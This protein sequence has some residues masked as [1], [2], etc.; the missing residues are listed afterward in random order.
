MELDP[1]LPLWLSPI[2]ASYN[3]HL[4]VLPKAVYELMFVTVGIK[5]YWEYR[6]LAVLAH[7]ACTTAIFA[8][9]FRRIGPMALLVAVPVAFFGA[10]SEF[11]LWGVN[12]GF[13][14]SIALGVSALMLIDRGDRHGYLGACALL[15]VGLLFSEIALLFAAGLAVE[16]TW[17]D[18]GFRRVWVWAVPAALYVAWWLAYYQA[19]LGKHAYGAVPKFIARLAAGAAGGMF[20]L[21]VHLGWG[22]LA[23]VIVG[24]AVVVVRRQVITPRLVGLAVTLAVFWTL[25]AVGRAQ[26]GDPGASRYV[27]MGSLLL[28][29][30]CGRG[31]PRPTANSRR[32]ARRD[33][34]Q[35]TVAVW[36]PA[37]LRARGILAAHGIAHRGCRTGCAPLGPCNSSSESGVGPRLGATGRCRTL[38]RRGRCAGLD[39]RRLSRSDPACPGADACRRRRGADTRRG[40]PTGGSVPH[41]LG[42]GSHTRWPRGRGQLVQSSRVPLLQAQ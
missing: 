25:V 18:R 1:V 14:A 39:T 3:Q 12:F 17:R 22:V 5:H 16:L 21:G 27:Y 42:R 29:L 31:V 4:L 10:G 37:R 13:T 7:L 34:A 15:T 20:G 23:A 41:R 28:L 32:G 2:L 6:L 30:A 11:I 35:R 24:L 40:D 36:E 19:D 33:R 8:Y 9:A 26:L 38:F